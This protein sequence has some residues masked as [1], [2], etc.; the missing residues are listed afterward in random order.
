MLASR[1]F[2]PTTPPLEMLTLCLRSCVISFAPP[3]SRK[4]SKMSG[5]TLS[6]AV[7]PGTASRNARGQQQQQQRRRNISLGSNTTDVTESL[8]TSL[9]G[10]G[11]T[12]SKFLR[13]AMKGAVTKTYE[14]AK[15]LDRY[16]ALDHKSPPSQFNMD[17]PGR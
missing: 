10:G 17:L 13:K 5:Q 9:D 6:G 2:A 8:L 16:V 14:V 3:G 7:V 1:E 4:M 11:G 15:S 12:N